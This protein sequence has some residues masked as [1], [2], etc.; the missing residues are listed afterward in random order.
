LWVAHEDGDLVGSGALARL[1]HGHEELKSMRTDPSRRGRG[2]ARRLLE[3]VL[4][5][6]R[7]RGVTR[8]SLE[9]GSMEFFAAA[10]A[11]YASTG[12][13]QCPPF[14]AYVEDP[15]SVFMTR[16]LVTGY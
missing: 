10:R 1:Q 6:A 9:T 7:A 14:G 3:F 5:D 12:F 16:E 13:A 11:L 8:I 2:I 15:N 4:D